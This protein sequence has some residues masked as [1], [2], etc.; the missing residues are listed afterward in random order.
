MGISVQVGDTVSFPH[1]E[2][3]LEG[4]VT[5]LL[6]TQC[7]IERD[8]QEYISFYNQLRKSHGEGK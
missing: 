4:E 7:V 2:E 8:G 6:S 3:I 5:V 1:G